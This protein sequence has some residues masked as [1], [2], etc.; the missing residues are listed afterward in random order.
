MLSR[1]IFNLI[2]IRDKSKIP[3]IAWGEYQQKKYEGEITSTNY[4]VICGKVSGCVVIDIDSPVLIHKLFKNWEGL[5]KGT[6]VIKTGSGGYH[7]YVRPKNGKFPPKM[8]L[9]NTIGQH[10][11]IQSD[12][13]YVIGPGSIHPN[14]NRYEIISSTNEV[15]EFDVMSFLQHIKQFGF[16]TE[17]GGLKR[18]EEI[19]K[20]GLGKGERNAS[21]FKYSIN[22][23][24][25]VG[26]DST[27]AWDETLR[28]NKTNKP[29][30]DERELRTTF[31]SALKKYAGKIQTP[32]TESETLSLKL[33]RDISATDEGKT[34]SFYGFVAAT[35]EHRT[36][37]KSLEHKCP[38]CEYKKVAVTDGFDNP[39]TPHCRDHKIEM[40][41]IE[42]TRVTEDVRTILIQEMPDEVQNNTPAR[43]TARVH[44]ELARLMYISSRKIL[45]IGKFRSVKVKGKMENEIIIEIEKIEYVDENLDKVSTTEELKK[46]DAMLADN[47][48]DK[49][50]DSFAPNI[51]GYDDIKKSILLHLVGGG[52]TRRSRIHI[53]I[54]GNPGR[55]KSELLNFTGK[56]GKSCYVNGKLASGAGLAAGIVK[57]STGASVPSTGA[58]TLY[59]FVMIDEMDKSRK[60]DRAAILECL[61]QGTVSLKKVGVDLTVP[62]NASILAAANPRLGKW[63]NE[64]GLEQNIN[65]ESFLL[66]RFDLIWGVIQQTNTERAKVAHHIIS[67]ATSEVVIPFSVDELKRYINFCKSIKPKLTEEAAKHLEDFY[68]RTAEFIQQNNDESLPLEERQLEGLIRLATAHAKLH[69]KDTVEV[70]DMQEAIRL[71]ESSLH[72]FGINTEQGTLQLDLRSPAANKEEA[73][74]GAI[75]G[76]VDDNKHFR[77]DDLLNKLKTYNKFFKSIHQAKNYFDEMAAKGRVLLN[78]DGSYR[79]AKL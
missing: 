17:Y 61:E 41:P 22:L 67:Q 78:E 51:F 66:S 11:D 77:H 38:T 72:S 21:A 27:T 20:G 52:N 35:D 10:I 63:K 42:T 19:A 26:M 64:M 43:K 31:E 1:D 55:G 12:G 74:F 25:N 62:A 8:P 4:A 24:E 15:I 39:R 57:L 18:F 75:Y 56:L 69:L 5:L 73:F 34:I 49:L 76:I 40:E 70:I 45:F 65:L 79:I 46:I 30:M 36:I 33:M 32:V 37:T 68:I 2:P 6:L 47:F 14:G 50:A 60:E 16:N 59:D 28:W 44:A 9:S 48:F 53:I 58:L 71:Y 29:P 54:I 13:S 7:V 23:L 3:A